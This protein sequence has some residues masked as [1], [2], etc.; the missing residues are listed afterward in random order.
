MLKGGIQNYITPSENLINEFMFNQKNRN[1][2]GAARLKT[3]HTPS[4][5]PKLLME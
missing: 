1:K 5:K 4:L 2:K 3:A